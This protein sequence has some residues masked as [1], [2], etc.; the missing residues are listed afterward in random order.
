MTLGS[1]HQH[2]MDPKFERSFPVVGKQTGG[3]AKGYAPLVHPS[4]NIIG[5]DNPTCLQ[6]Q[7]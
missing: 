7:T 6:L 3:I 1:N 4:E 2:G 5:P